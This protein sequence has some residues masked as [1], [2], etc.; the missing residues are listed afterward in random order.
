MCLKIDPFLSR[1]YCWLFFLFPFLSVGLPFHSMA[2]DLDNGFYDYGLAS[3]DTN[4]H[5]VTAIQESNRSSFSRDGTMTNGQPTFSLLGLSQGQLIGGTKSQALKEGKQ[6]EQPAELFILD[7]AAKEVEWHSAV[8][9][10][11]QEYT[12][13]CMGPKDG[14]IYG[15]A[16]RKVF[17]V[18]DPVKR[19]ILHSRPVDSAFGTTPAKA[20]HH[21]FI[22]DPM[23]EVYLL[24]RHGIGH[25][26]PGSYEITMIARSPVPIDPGGRYADG[27]IYFMSG[28]HLC[29]YQPKTDLSKANKAIDYFKLGPANILKWDKGPVSLGLVMDLD[30]TPVSGKNAQDLMIGRIWK[31][32]YIYPSKGPFSG[33][34]LLEQPQMMGKAGIL[35]FQ[36]VDWNQDGVTDLIAGTRNGFLY[37]IPGKGTYPHTNYDI[38][39]KTIM[40]DATSHLP[41]NIPYQNP[42]HTVDDLGGYLDVQYYNYIYPKVY[43][44]PY[45]KHFQDLI[46][47]DFAGNLWWI[48][49]QSNGNGKPA[50]KGIK[51]TKK[52]TFQRIGATY[53]KEL[54][55]SYVKPA[56]RILDEKGHPFL[57]GK[58][59]DGETFYDG[60]NTRP[61]SY[62]D[63]SG[64]NGLLVIAGS[65]LQQIYY[66][67]RVNALHERKPVFKNM[68][69]VF[70]EGLDRI[71]LNFHSKVCL[72]E[73]HGRNDLLLATNNHVAIIKN[74]GWSNGVP[75]FVFSGWV[76]G[77][78]VAGSF[79]AF[80]DMLTD[81]LGKRYII[82]F[83]GTYAGTS[84]WNLI[85]VEKTN[86]GIRLH[87]TDSLKIMDQ[88]GVFTVEGE[89]DPQLSPQWGYH[90]ISKWN[91]DGSGR[92]HLI[93]GTDKGLLFLLIDDPVLSNPGEFIFRSMGPLK[94]SSGAIIKIHNR[95]VAAGL[96]LND[97]GREDLLVGGISYQ[98]GIKTDPQ[99]GGGV[100]YMLNLGNDAQGVPILTPP[101]PLDLGSEFKPRMNSHVGLQVLDIDHDNQKEII[102]SLQDPGWDGRIY[103][104]QHGRIGVY[105]TGFKVPVHP[106]NEQILDIDGDGNYELVWPGGETGV[107][108]FKRLEK[109]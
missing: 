70:I 90:R 97:D 76:K 27:R 66:L 91:F 84:Y 80:D 12:D 78:D 55:L 87:Y 108:N 25:I 59:R 7:R 24:F 67:K 43:R 33:R 58:A 104:K 53:Q 101:Q 103:R 62:P 9:P 40:R 32:V 71:N 34:T 60:S 49:D 89:T 93:V 38:S 31:G 2:Q 64:A 99:P 105:Y 72:Y 47:G 94:D 54:G 14:F 11:V 86:H 68:G 6:K 30:L 3:L 83:A 5:V 81:S 18:F 37:L 95:A 29:S 85:P 102:V 44:S 52:I 10:A 39:N 73:N 8:L 21:I 26:E 1:K 28:S 109:N 82:H 13:L 41:F 46:I 106:I 79:Y 57:L 35:L 75:R 65:N 88:H 107:G 4:R 15:I 74:L 22:I 69:E 100:Y 50:Y 61:I 23:G 20:Y 36:P 98:L 19:K 56:E 51:Y 42:Y 48:P 96:D 92:N 16:D 17:F 77:Q 63:R 45:F